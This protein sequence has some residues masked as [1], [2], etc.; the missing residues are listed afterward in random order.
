MKMKK[1]VLMLGGSCLA[2]S[3]FAAITATSNDFSGGDI[4][5]WT[6]VG[7]TSTEIVHDG[8]SAG[9]YDDGD[10]TLKLEYTAGM[11][12]TGDGVKDDGGLRFNTQNAIQG[13]EAIGLTIAGTMEEG[14]EITFSGSVYNDNSSYSKYNAQLWNLT[15]GTLLAESGFAL[16]QAL[17]HIAYVPVDFNISYI[18]TAAD[19]GDTLQ[20]RFVEDANS[21]AR[22]I[23]VDNF[24]LTSVPLN[25]G[26]T[27]LVWDF[28]DG[29][30]G[31]VLTNNLA[32]YDYTSNQG[33]D[34][35]NAVVNTLAF[36]GRSTGTDYIIRDKGAGHASSLFVKTINTSKADFGI[37]VQKLDFTVAGMNATNITRVSWSFD[38]LGYDQNGAFDPT[39]WTVKV[40]SDNTDPGINVSDAWFSSAALAQTFDFLDDTTG[41]TALN[42]TWTTITGSYDI[43]VGTAG[44]FG[45]IQISTDAG[46]YTSSGG[47][48][49]DNLKVTI[50]SAAP[51]LG[52]MYDAW[53]AGYGLTNS[54]AFDPGTDFDGDQLSNLEE[55]G[56]GGNPTNAA[57]TGFAAVTYPEAGDGLIYIYPQRHDAAIAGL[58]Y[59]TERTDDLVSGTWVGTGIEELGTGTDVF[60]TGFDGVTNRI[61]TAAD[62]QQFI[63]LHINGL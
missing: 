3:S 27:K 60:D 24:E 30:S 6:S 33:Y 37:Y 47:V 55:Y 58:T 35:S 28:N 26:T 34:G 32:K 15:D 7:A 31:T 8:T 54:P 43:A 12:L 4:T 63:Q 38:I 14:E 62:A 50:A 21:T 13:D 59:S 18:A 61:S 1:L 9:D 57:D 46:G 39:N 53:A 23:Y 56:L 5:G 22:D 44:T 19:A 49:I 52:D 51:V 2:A 42:G 48:F 41:E 40:R 16:V 10:P 17:S 25:P 11:T 36:N 20:I 45:G 29:A